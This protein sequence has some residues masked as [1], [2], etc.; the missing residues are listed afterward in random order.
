M[1]NQ[2]IIDA[3][4]DQ[5]TRDIRKQLVESILRSEKEK[6]QE[7]IDSSYKIINQIFSYVISELGWTFSIDS[8]SWNDTPLK[9]MLEV[10]PNIDKTEWF[11]SQLLQVKKT[12]ELKGE[13]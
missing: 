7:A 11:D 9:I 8:Q 5:Y 10:F 4:K 3:I 12:V 13:F 6:D 1:E 2:Q